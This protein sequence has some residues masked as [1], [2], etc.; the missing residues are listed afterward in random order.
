VG[1]GLARLDLAVEGEKGRAHGIVE[2][3]VRDHHVEHGLGL[4]RD[5]VPD[6]ERHQHAPRPGGDR[7]SAAVA[8]RIAGE[9]RVAE[10]DVEVPAERALQ[11]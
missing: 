6:A 1:E 2:A 11:R 5:R 7:V 4:G 3:A 10:N 9:R 8:G